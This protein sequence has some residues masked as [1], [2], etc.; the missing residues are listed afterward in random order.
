MAVCATALA[1]ALAGGTLPAAAD[2]SPLF[3]RPVR[4]P[5]NGADRRRLKRGAG[6]WTAPPP[7]LPVRGIFARVTP[8]Q[9]CA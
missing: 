1:A 4:T 3:R 9:E 7:G 2:H 8:W 5:G 6:S